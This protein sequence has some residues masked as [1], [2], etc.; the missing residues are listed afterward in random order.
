VSGHFFDLRGT[1]T[2]TSYQVSTQ[3]RFAPQEK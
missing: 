2:A 3:T 1:A